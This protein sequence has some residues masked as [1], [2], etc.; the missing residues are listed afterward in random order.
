MQQKTKGCCSAC[1]VRDP[2]PVSQAGRAQVCA[3]LNSPS[4]SQSLG[5]LVYF[6]CH[7]QKPGSSLNRRQPQQTPNLF[8]QSGSGH[9]ESQWLDRTARSFTSSSVPALCSSTPE[10]P[11]LKVP[12]GTPQIPPGGFGEGERRMNT[13]EHTAA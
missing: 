5:L 2:M 12:M 6:L 8:L 13:T 7:M 4:G 11:A 3:C 9:T 1:T 10:S